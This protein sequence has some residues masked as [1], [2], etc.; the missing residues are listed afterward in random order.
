[1][2]REFNRLIALLRQNILAQISLAIMTVVI[3]LA[4]AAPLLPFQ[5]PE[6]QD[7]MATLVPPAFAGGDSSHFLGTDYLGRDILSRIVWGSQISLLVGFAVVALA[8]AVGVAS[9]LIA[10][11]YGGLLEE[12]VMRVVDLV[13]TIPQMLIAIAVLAIF[14]QSLTILILVLGLR[15]SVW[16]ARTIRSK[17][18]T[19]KKEQYVGAARAMGA[20]SLDIMWRHILPNSIAPIIVLSTVY[21]GLIIVIESGLSFLGLTKVSISWGWMIAE[22]RDYLST[23]WW[24]ATMPGLALFFTVFSINILG[25]LVRDAFDPS[26]SGEG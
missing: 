10:T 13:L 22:S 26:I 1:M 24:T 14:G 23:S 18:L 3:F 12:A 4:V 11:Y 8:L 15:T 5:D 19:I 2:Q 25:D 16:Y 20:S 17:V 21:V 9:G 6:A 7:L